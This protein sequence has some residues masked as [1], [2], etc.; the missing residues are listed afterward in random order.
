MTKQQF[1]EK[2]LEVKEDVC[3]NLCDGEYL[4][5]I[6]EELENKG[7]TYICAFNACL[8]DN[9]TLEEIYHTAEVF[10]FDES[11]YVLL[12]KYMILLNIARQIHEK[13]EG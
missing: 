12:M 5:N 11:D 8:G 7:T 3:S 9:N 4:E 13:M 10:R 1:T 6:A 2:F